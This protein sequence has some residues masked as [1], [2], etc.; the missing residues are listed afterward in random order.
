MT[1]QC[2]FVRVL[3]VLERVVMV[4]QKAL[5]RRH[6]DLAFILRHQ[7]VPPHMTGIGALAHIPGV[8]IRLFADEFLVNRKI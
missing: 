6:V 7:L 1:V 4:G 8:E 2:A 3:F 5:C